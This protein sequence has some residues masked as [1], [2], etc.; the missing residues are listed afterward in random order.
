MSR[1][2]TVVLYE[3]QLCGEK[4]KSYGPHVLALAC[5]ADRRACDRWNIGR[6]I[7]GRPCKGNAKLRWQVA[8]NAGRLTRACHQVVA[9]FDDDKVRG[10]YGLHA[11]ECRPAVLQAIK[12]Q[13]SAPI[14]V[15][16]LERNMESLVD[17]CCRCLRRTPPDGKPTPRERD[18]ILHDAANAGRSVRD[19]IL[20]DMTSFERLV[21]VLE[22]V[23]VASDG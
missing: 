8:Q 21:S 9:V 19:A 16:L 23:V 22:N 11:S 13:A 4:P 17:A 18:A 14:T 12:G 20:A 5:V 1:Y 3:D 15:V 10:C 6:Q 2:Q 7:D